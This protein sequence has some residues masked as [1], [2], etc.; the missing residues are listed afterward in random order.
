MKSNLKKK[1]SRKA[2]WDKKINKQKQRD[3]QKQNEQK[4]IILDL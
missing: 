1:H 2:E 4:I 3:N